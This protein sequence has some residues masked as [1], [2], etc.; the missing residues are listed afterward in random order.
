MP[1][2]ITGSYLQDRSSTMLDLLRQE[3]DQENQNNIQNVAPLEEQNQ[4]DNSQNNQRLTLES[5]NLDSTAN[6]HSRNLIDIMA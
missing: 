2:G 3:N 5:N 1:M 4:D 6:K